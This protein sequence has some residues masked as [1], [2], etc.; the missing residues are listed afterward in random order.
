MGF[1]TLEDV[2]GSIELVIFTRVWHRVNDWLEPGIIVQV[3]GKIDQER[4]DPKVLVD[5]ISQD[6][7]ASVGDSHN[8]SQR[9]EP[10]WGPPDPPEVISDPGEVISEVFHSPPE[11]II[12]DADPMMAGGWDL[13][14]ENDVPL[15]PES[16][17]AVAE[18]LE[19]ERVVEDESEQPDEILAEIPMEAQDLQQTEQKSQFASEEPEP[20]QVQLGESLDEFSPQSQ[21]E[22]VLMESDLAPFSGVHPGT[23]GDLTMVKVF[24]RSTGDK[25]RDSLRMRRVY[26]LLTT[27]PGSDRFAV[28]IF[29]GSR[30]YHLEFPNETTG[31]CPELQVRLQKLVGD[32]NIQIEP[33]RLQ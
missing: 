6:I 3:E 4:G 12:E 9:K 18:T 7:S 19:A 31:F 21:E 26:G 24:L 5:K 16:A 23:G 13:P 11:P 17:G 2:Q 29:E 20:P 15:P 33:L 27:Y 28:Y 8:V 14:V 30:R 22:A 32:T 10:S 1:A 25:K